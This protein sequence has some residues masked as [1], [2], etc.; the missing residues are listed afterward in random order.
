MHPVPPPGESPH[1]PSGK[2]IDP[3]AFALD[4]ARTYLRW[5][6]EHRASFEA[7]RTSDPDTAERELGYLAHSTGEALTH[8]NRLTELLLAGYTIDPAKRLPRDLAGLAAGIAPAV[9]SGR[10]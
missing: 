7:A 6:D 9:D 2:D 5:V 3:V 4:R 8:I 1:D 10:G